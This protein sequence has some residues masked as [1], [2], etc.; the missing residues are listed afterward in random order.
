MSL[1]YPHFLFHWN[2]IAHIPIL[3]SCELSNLLKLIILNRIV[4]NGVGGYFP[5][6]SNSS[7]LDDAMATYLM[8]SQ[9]IFL[10]IS[11]QQDQSLPRILRCRRRRPPLLAD[12]FQMTSYVRPKW[13]GFGFKCMNTC[14]CF[15]M[16]IGYGWFILATIRVISYLS[17][18][19]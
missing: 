5:F 2:R 3:L 18:S 17:K 11:I 9:K 7:R 8:H 19:I 14:P 13:L 16:K 15:R 1:S 12:H 6:N 4:W 10:C